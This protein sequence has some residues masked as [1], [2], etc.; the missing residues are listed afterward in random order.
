[1]DY[2][3]KVPTSRLTF[4]QEQK[5]E[6]TVF[7]VFLVNPYLYFSSSVHTHTVYIATGHTATCTYYHF[8]DFKLS[9]Q[10]NLIPMHKRNLNN[11]NYKIRT[12]MN[13]MN[14]LGQISHK[15]SILSLKFQLKY[16][17]L[18]V[19]KKFWL[20]NLSRFNILIHYCYSWHSSIF[21]VSAIYLFWS[22]LQERNFCLIPGKDLQGN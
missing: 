21:I 9:Q 6:E 12:N 14:V 7:L 2:P 11:Q 15:D 19:S 13:T 3:H 20:Y 5:K 22:L 17:F 4:N 10:D 1:M 8:L 18:S 16:P